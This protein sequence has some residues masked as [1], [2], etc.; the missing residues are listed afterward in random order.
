MIRLTASQAA[1]SAAWGQTW[2]IR[3]PVCSAIDSGEVN[4]AC[5][6]MWDVLG[7]ER[8]VKN[9]V[10]WSRIEQE[11]NK[12]GVQ[13]LR[14]CT[15]RRRARSWPRQGRRRRSILEPCGRCEV[16][17]PQVLHLRQRPLESLLQVPIG[18]RM[19]S[20]QA[21]GAHFHL[22]PLQERARC[23]VLRLSAEQGVQG[24]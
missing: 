3:I 2:E 7:G 1:A 15:L 5:E 10:K 22:T 23:A 4:L 20:V 21:Q 14:R 24:E 11:K 8:S 18:R 16:L 12:P 6:E 17:E 19:L 13:Q 9:S